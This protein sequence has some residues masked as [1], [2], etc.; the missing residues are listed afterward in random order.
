MPACLTKGCCSSRVVAFLK[1]AQMCSSTIEPRPAT[2]FPPA[3]VQGAGSSRQPARPKRSPR[4]IT[5]ERGSLSSMSGHL[6]G[7]SHLS[8]SLMP[9]KAVLKILGKVNSAWSTYCCILKWPLGIMGSTLSAPSC[10]RQ[11]ALSQKEKRH[12]YWP[13]VLYIRDYFRRMTDTI[14]MQSTYTL[15]GSFIIVLFAH[16]CP[17]LF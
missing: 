3:G 6:I 7:L 4:N 15:L 5:N 8:T 16:S 1:H 11:C 14:Y 10:F 12:E 9:L 13:N 17:C 2:A